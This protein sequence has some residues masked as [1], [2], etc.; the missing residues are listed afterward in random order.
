MTY[1]GAPPNSLC[2]TQCLFRH[3]CTLEED[4]KEDES[5]MQLYLF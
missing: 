3:R 1:A 5:G 4:K 2:E